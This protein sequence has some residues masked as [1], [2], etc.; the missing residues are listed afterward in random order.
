MNQYNIM[1]VKLNNSQ[2]HKLKSRKDSTG[3]TVRLSLNTI[4]ATH[5]GTANHVLFSLTMTIIFYKP[6]IRH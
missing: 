4:Y 1:N 6:K 3:V 5:A 2:I